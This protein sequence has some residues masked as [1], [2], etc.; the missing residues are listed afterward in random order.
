[1]WARVMPGV[2]PLNCLEGEKMKRPL[3]MILTFSIIA[4]LPFAAMAKV[5]P[6]SFED[7]VKGSDYIVIGKVQSVTSVEDVKVP[8]I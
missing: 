6:I 3:S 1:M 4:L 5:G 7:L 2:M 8:K